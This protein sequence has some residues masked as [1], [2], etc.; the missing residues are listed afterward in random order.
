M[1]QEE[2]LLDLDELEKVGGGVNLIT[3]EGEVPTGKVS[4]AVKTMAGTEQ[5]TTAYC[6]KC[7]KMRTFRLFK[8]GRAYCEKC[9]S[10]K[11][12]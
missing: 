3:P 10:E 5:T 6:E 2:R 11:D 12:L 7:G 8:G 4:S 1:G 9:G